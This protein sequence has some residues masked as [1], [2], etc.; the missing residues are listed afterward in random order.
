MDEDIRRL[1]QESKIGRGYAALLAEA[2]TYT[3]PEEM[4]EKEIVIKASFVRAVIVHVFTTHRSFTHDVEPLRN[5]YLLKYPG[6]LQ[7][8]SVHATAGRLLAMLPI[9]KNQMSST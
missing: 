3:K 7:A 5:L 8:P 4:K 9:K 1:F 6:S 2:I